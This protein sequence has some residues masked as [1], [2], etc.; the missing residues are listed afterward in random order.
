MKEMIFPALV[1]FF[2]LSLTAISHNVGII[3]L[4]F[5]IWLAAFYWCWKLY[6]KE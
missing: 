4:G 6:Q 2:G 3:I 1:A 5:A